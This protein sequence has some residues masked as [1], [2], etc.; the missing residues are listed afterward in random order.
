MATVTSDFDVPRTQSRRKAGPDRARMRAFQKARRHSHWVRL[1]RLLMPLGAVAALGLYALGGPMSLSIGDGKL[2]FEG[3]KIDPKNLTMSNPVYE[4]FTDDNGTY[5][6]KAV[7]ATQQLDKPDL[8]G[9]KTVTAKLSEAD[10]GT[11]EMAAATGEIDTKKEVLQLAGGIDV[12]SSDGLKAK[13]KTA[14]LYLKQKRILS[15]EPVA[16]EMPNGTVK[17]RQLEIFTEEKRILF[18]TNVVTNLVPP[19]KAEAGKAKASSGFASAAAFGD[20]PILINSD[21]LDVRDTEKTALFSGNVRGRQA[22]ST[23]TAPTMHVTYSGNSGL[24]GESAGAATGTEISMIESKGGVVIVTDDKRSAKSEWSLYD[25]LGQTITLGGGV[26]LVSEGN[27]IEGEKLVVD[28]E[29][30]ISRFPAGSRVRGQFGTAQEAGKA[31]KQKKKPAQQQGAIGDI[32]SFTT[33]EGGP[34]KIESNSLEVHDAKGLAY[35]RGN[36]IAS[37]GGQQIKAEA[38]DVSYVSGEAAKLPEG[39]DN[40]R[41]IIATGNVVVSAPDDQVVTGD[42]LVYDAKSQII[43]IT[44]NVTTS[45]GKNVIKG[46]KLVVNLETGE[47]AFDTAPDTVAEGVQQVKKRV[48]MLIDP[49]EV[50]RTTN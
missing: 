26:L 8:V 34:T 48:K 1:L 23:F 21:L 14:M 17:S 44:G 29:K 6:V 39:Q 41:S 20:G 25:R 11:A 4:G 32:T 43:T 10:G 40:I 9:L 19:K 5:V 22:G 16:V 37:R 15:Q 35:F 28:L 38:L 45:Q 7:S 30:S 27:R 49:D 42:K 13:L 24:G 33:G 2:G 3:I 50:P 12:K 47:S 46:D 31:K 18:K 36:V